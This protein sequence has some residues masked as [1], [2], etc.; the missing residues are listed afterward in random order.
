[1]SGELDSLRKEI[2]EAFHPW[3]RI[4]RPLGSPFSVLYDRG[5]FHDKT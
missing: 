1:M 5:I 2:D 4:V 3:S